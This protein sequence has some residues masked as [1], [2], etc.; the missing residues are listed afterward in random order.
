[1]DSFINANI[2]SSVLQALEKKKNIGFFQSLTVE[3]NHDGTIRRPPELVAL[4][5][6]KLI[7]LQ[8]GFMVRVEQRARPLS[9]LMLHE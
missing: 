6:Q 5:E 4:A 7:E 2:E 1:M 8:V 9:P 3:L